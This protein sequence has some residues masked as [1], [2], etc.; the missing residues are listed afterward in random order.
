MVAVARAA[1]DTSNRTRTKSGNPLLHVENENGFSLVE[2]ITATVIAAV[3]VIGLAYSF[4]TGRTLIDRFETAR[5]A[6]GSAEERLAI[7]SETAP[8]DTAFDIG[9]H[10][11]GFFSDGQMIGTQ[12]WTVSDWDDPAAGVDDSLKRVIVAVTWSWGTFDDT[13][14]IERLFPA[15]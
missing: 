7:L 3:A 4:S 5:E 9:T 6:L 1:T 10:T 14:R 8:S 11:A 12:I 2:V 15:R 13:V